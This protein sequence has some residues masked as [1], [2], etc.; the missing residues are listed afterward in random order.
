MAHNY[1]VEGDLNAELDSSSSSSESESEVEE[2]EHF[3][4]HEQSHPPRPAYNY[5]DD[6]DEEEIEVFSGGS[7][8]VKSTTKT[9]AVPSSHIHE[10]GKHCT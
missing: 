4:H 3:Q 6:D 7:S 9:A 1:I 5:N 2:D 8:T 10:E